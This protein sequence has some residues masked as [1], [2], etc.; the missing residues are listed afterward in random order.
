Q[1]QSQD[2]SQSDRPPWARKNKSKSTSSTSGKSAPVA[3]STSSTASPNPL[4]PVVNPTESGS[5]TAGTAT[6]NASDDQDQQ[7]GRIR[8]N[9]TLFSILASVLDDH[10]RPAADLPREAFHLY[11]EGVEQKIEI[12]EQETQQPIDIALMVDAS[13]SAH[14]EIIFE[15]DSATRFLR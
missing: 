15:Q 10:N 7:R 3:D 14:K 4:P 6:R 9:V 13:L 2:P 12:F 11:E 8:V 5:S 1:A